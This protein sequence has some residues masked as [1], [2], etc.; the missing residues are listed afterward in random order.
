MLQLDVT[1]EPGLGRETGRVEPLDRGRVSLLG[2]D[3]AENVVPRSVAELIV[4]GMDAEGRRRRRSVLDPFAKSRLDQVVER[5][6]E[7]AAVPRRCRPG[8]LHPTERPRCHAQ[9][10]TVAAWEVAVAGSPDGLAV[11]DVSSSAPRTAAIVASMS[12]VSIP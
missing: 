6:V 9:A 3:L 12:A 7:R 4:P 11:P 8:E 2:I 10:L 5:V 1:L